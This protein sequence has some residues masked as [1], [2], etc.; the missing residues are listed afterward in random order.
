MIKNHYKT[1]APGSNFC[2]INPEN[3]N[4]FIWKDKN[5]SAVGS[6]FSFLRSLVKSSILAYHIYAKKTVLV[7]LVFST[8]DMICRIYFPIY[9]PSH[10]WPCIGAFIF[11]SCFDK[12]LGKL[13]EYFE[14]AMVE[15]FVHLL[16]VVCNF[17]Y[18]SM[19]S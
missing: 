1:V 16:Y 9:N 6:S 4:V 5:W 13:T 15:F 8:G 3:L 12:S 2:Q 10:N 7:L 11:C 17:V 19:K 18:V 14:S